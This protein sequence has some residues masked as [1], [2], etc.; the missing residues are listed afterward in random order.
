MEMR[1]LYNVSLPLERD[2]SEDRKTHEDVIKKNESCLNLNF[3][4]ISDKLYE[5][6]LRLAL[7]ETAL[8]SREG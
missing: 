4:M 3:G 6:E 2:D 8:E 5:L 7:I 1:A